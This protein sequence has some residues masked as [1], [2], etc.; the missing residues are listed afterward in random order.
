MKTKIKNARRLETTI[1]DE[2]RRLEFKICNTSGGHPSYSEAAKQTEARL[3]PLIQ[4]HKHMN[5]IKFHIREAIG[6]F[7]V[8]EGIN[9]HTLEIARK[10]AEVEMW[11]KVNTI[12]E[13][14]SQTNYHRDTSPIIYNG[15]ISDTYSEEMHAKV[16][17][18]NREIVR[19]KDKCMGVNSMGSIE[20]ND[21]DYTF[22]QEKGLLD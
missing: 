2:I 7:N 18:L 15:G 10:M 14:R 9:A 21:S 13:P 4:T 12:S 5:K 6:I 3:R 22:L 1:I 20:I 16:L 11:E 19:L 17:K 8:E